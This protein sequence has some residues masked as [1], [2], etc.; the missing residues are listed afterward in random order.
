MILFEYFLSPQ[1]GIISFD[2]IIPI[3]CPCQWSE[4]QSSPFPKG[5]DA[6]KLSLALPLH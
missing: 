3:D 2:I 6:E 4:V 5:W 1:K